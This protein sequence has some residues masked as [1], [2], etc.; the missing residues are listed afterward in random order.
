[1]KELLLKSLICVVLAIF[2]VN[3]FTAISYADNFD[4]SGYD[5]TADSSIKSPFEGAIGAILSV[6]RIVGTGVALIII[7]TIAIKYM[8]AAPGERAE[9]KKS[10]IQYVV[11]ALILFGSSN[12]L[13]ILVRVFGEVFPG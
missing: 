7:M 3:F 10:S 13:S 4:L 5:A 6:I 2:V 9:I 1:M 8:S 12:I 11:G